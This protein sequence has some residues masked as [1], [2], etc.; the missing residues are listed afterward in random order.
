MHYTKGPDLESKSART[1]RRHAAKGTFAGQTRLDSFRSFSIPSSG[2]GHRVRGLR[3]LPSPSDLPPL[4]EPIDFSC[5]SEDDVLPIVPSSPVT[6]S[7]N[8]VNLA[9]D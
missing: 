4:N 5:D 3:S 9:P 6:V 2:T 7:P 8:P 1:V